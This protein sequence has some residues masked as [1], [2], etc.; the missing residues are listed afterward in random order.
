MFQAVSAFGNDQSFVV[1]ASPGQGSGRCD[2]WFYWFTLSTQGQ[3]G[4][5]QPLLIP[6]VNGVVYAQ[7]ALAAS[8]DGSTVAYSAQRCPSARTGEIGVIHLTTG[9]V[10][11]YGWSQ[12]GLPRELSLSANGTVLC[13]VG[14]PSNGSLVGNT[15]AE[16]AYLVNTSAPAGP[17]ASHYRKALHTQHGMPAA[18]ISPS[19]AVL[20]AMTAVTTRRGTGALGKVSGHAGTLTPAREHYP[21]AGQELGA[22]Q[23][24]TGRLITAL[25]E[26]PMHL[27]ETGYAFSADTSGHYAL[28]ILQQASVQEL[29]L[30]TGRTRVI[31]IRRNVLPFEAAW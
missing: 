14:D 11:A 8:A 17:L 30:T 31:P 9:S 24:A 23:G 16:S 21:Y 27:L 13:Y 12:V 3:L 7:S 6:E 10:T 28:A 29:S 1:A 20:F 2:T 26:I 4:N 5:M 19:S 18:L 25:H 15:D 22:Y